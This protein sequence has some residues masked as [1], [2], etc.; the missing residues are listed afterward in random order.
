[1]QAAA[2][3]L[4]YLREVVV[5]QLP[6]TLQ[7]PSDLTPEGLNM[8]ENIMCA[9]VRP[10]D[11]AGTDWKAFFEPAHRI[12]PIAGLA[13]QAQ[14]CFYEK[15]VTDGVKSSVIA[16]LAAQ[17][18]S[19]STSPLLSPPSLLWPR[20]DTYTGLLEWCRDI[21]L[22]SEELTGVTWSLMNGGT[23]CVFPG[24]GLLHGGTATC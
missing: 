23:L 19:A 24:S 11:R 22:V 3:V 12:A 17:V 20:I 9:Q 21:G 14:A 15:A 1:M 6:H 10:H 16:S 18:L 7:V 5:P 13:M 2:S 8:F 4:K